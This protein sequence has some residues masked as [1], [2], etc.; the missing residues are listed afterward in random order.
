MI[1]VKNIR[2]VL[3]IGDKQFKNEFELL[4]RLEHKNIVQ[5]LG[6]CNETED[7]LHQYQG[8][9]V[10]A[11]KI[12]RALCLEFVPN[13]NLGKFLSGMVIYAEY[14]VNM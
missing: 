12:H 11:V 13:G 14:V 9:M 1:A 10:E 8:R 4:R 5:L 6:F 3:E 2:F 7:V